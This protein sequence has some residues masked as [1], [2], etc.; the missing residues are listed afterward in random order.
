MS[1]NKNCN[2]QSSIQADILQAN[3]NLFASNISLPST[4]D[5]LNTLTSTSIGYTING[6]PNNANIINSTSG[7][8][9]IL[10]YLTLPIGIWLLYGSVE[11][12]SASATTLSYT[13]VISQLSTTYYNKNNISSSLVFDDTIV[14]QISGIVTVN[15]NNTIINLFGTI[16]YS[17]GIP[18]SKLQSTVT[19]GITTTST[20]GTSFNIFLENVSIVIGMK[21][22]GSGIVGSPIVMT[23]SG[24]TITMNTA[25]NIGGSV[26]LSFTLVKGPCFLTATR[27]G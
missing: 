22:S 7:V 12:Y 26:N 13:K 3:L 15:T 2:N 5:Y 17:A 10:F 18:I 23:V 27:I 11:I 6:T 9:A 14:N 1:Y 24:T 21:V 19:Q 25:Q 16:T 4:N 8:S 20:T